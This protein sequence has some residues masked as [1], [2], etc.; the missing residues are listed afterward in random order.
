METR[1][2]ELSFGTK[3]NGIFC[4]IVG[5]ISFLS[6]DRGFISPTVGPVCMK[7]EVCPEVMET[8]GEVEGVPGSLTGGLLPREDH[9]DTR[10]LEAGLVRQEG[11]GKHSDSVDRG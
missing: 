8:R 6:F 1:E 3:I 4:F 7:L 10:I 2:Q 5:D 11:V 9:M